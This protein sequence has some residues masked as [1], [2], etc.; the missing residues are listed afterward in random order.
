MMRVAYIV[1]ILALCVA[2]NP[3]KRLNRLLMRYPELRDTVVIHD[4]VEAIVEYVRADTVVRW[5]PGDTIYL[6]KDR[7][8]IRTVIDH[9][10][11]WQ[12]GECLSDTI[13]VPYRVE[14]PVVQPLRTIAQIP[15]WYWLMVGGLILAVILTAMRR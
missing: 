11:V 6:T 5:K 7:L 4:T 14:V 15:W 9:D 8:R 12:V 1:A 13:R 3:Q 10:T 2:C